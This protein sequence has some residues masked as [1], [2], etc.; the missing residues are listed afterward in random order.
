MDPGAGLGWITGVPLAPGVPVTVK[1]GVAVA[2]AVGVAEGGGVAVRVRVR[3]GVRVKV[4]V[5]E[6]V[7]VEV[8]VEVRVLVAVELGV[9]VPVAAA[10]VMTAPFKGAPLKLTGPEA[11]DPVRSVLERREAWKVPVAVAE[12]S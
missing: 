6:A 11:L 2:V 7:A 5:E 3:V 4:E 12:K 8:T 9:G 1:E 10:T